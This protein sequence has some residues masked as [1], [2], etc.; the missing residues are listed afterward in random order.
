MEQLATPKQ[1]EYA[2][3]MISELGYDL[4]DYNLPDMTV[5]EISQLIKELKEE[6]E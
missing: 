5:S 2:T 1:I 4:D 3:L 6:L